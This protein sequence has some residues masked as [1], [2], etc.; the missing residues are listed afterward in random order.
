MKKVLLAL[1]LLAVAADSPEAVVKY[2]QSVMKTLA[3]QMTA[4]SLIAKHDVTPS[5]NRLI[6]HATAA[7][8]FSRDLPKLFPASTR[9]VRSS[10]LPKI[11]SS[12]SDFDRRAKNLEAETV[13]LESLA[14][15]GMSH[16]FAKQLEVVGATCKACHDVYRQ[17]D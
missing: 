6:L 5:P 11:W 12:A 17:Q 1:A 14:R 13:K 3:A 4:M 9:N 2:R 7:A 10:A 15:S 8:D 16:S